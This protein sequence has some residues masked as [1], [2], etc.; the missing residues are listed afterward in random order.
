MA[1]VD[2]E[3][4]NQINEW[5]LEL[6]KQRAALKDENDTFEA[7][8]NAANVAHDA[9]IGPI[10]VKI[11]ELNA[12][13]DALIQE[14][15]AELIKEGRQSFVTMVVK[16]Q[17]HR[18]HPKPK[19]TNPKA[20]MAIARARG[21]VRK[22][23]KLVSLWKF[24]ADKFFAWLA[25]NEELRSLFDEYIDDTEENES[26]S[27][28]LNGAYPVFH[29]GARLSSESITIRESAPRADSATAS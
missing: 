9:I 16:F 10:Q 4:V 27:M 25:K 29:D 13:L 22:I 28:Q 7:E 26:L 15:R 17:F 21:I 12:K 20:V 2:P 14:H 23:A 5:A 3:V 19:V 11:N 1:S 8:Q 6:L 18:T 24:D